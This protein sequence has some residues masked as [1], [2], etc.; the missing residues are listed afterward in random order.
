MNMGVS[1]LLV[2]SE[3]GIWDRGNWCWWLVGLLFGFFVRI[4][5]VISPTDTLE[6]KYCLLNSL[7]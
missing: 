1:S 5:G 7:C 3:Y 2:N 6:L 4:C